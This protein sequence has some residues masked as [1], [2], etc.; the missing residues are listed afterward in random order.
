MLRSPQ[1]AGDDLSTPASRPRSHRPLGLAATV[2]AASLAANL[3]SP[4][5]VSAK[6]RAAHVRVETARLRSG[7]DESKPLVG[8]LDSG[9]IARVVDRRGG[10]ARVH[11]LSGTEGW[12][13]SDLLKVSR[14]AKVAKAEAKQAAKAK[15]LA[16]AKAAKAK[17]LAALQAK[18]LA[19]AKAAKA[20]HQAALAAQA[21]RAQKLAATAAAAKAKRLAAARLA[22]AKQIA[23]ARA[24]AQ[25]V[26][27]VRAQ[28]LAVKQI[29]QA[30]AK[31]VTAMLKRAAS[32]AA[33]MLAVPQTREH[34]VAALRPRHIPAAAPILDAAGPAMPS[35]ETTVLIAATAPRPPVQ[36]T[37]AV[38]VASLDAPAPALRVVPAAPAPALP[39]APALA[40][41]VA[42]ALPV[43]PAAP[44]PTPGERMV[45]TALTYRGTR[46]RFGARGNGAFD[47]SGFTYYLWRRAGAPL[48]RTAAQ[49][50]RRGVRIAKQNMQPGD[51]V[52]FKNTYKRGVSH[53]GVYVGDG[54]FV[55]ASSGGR[56]VRVDSL[57]RAYYVRHWAGARRMASVA[58]NGK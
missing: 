45:R 2:G 24:K 51:L 23:L 31:V 38:R 58:Q 5:S 55:H 49:Q 22:Q 52:F 41:P 9:R 27:A 54:N 1:I 34:A 25:R 29:A 37:V 18:Q 21:A 12:V 43:A 15:K 13:R 19:A 33:P 14:K 32:L 39:A 6:P 30:R 57:S 56:Q 26:A 48:P 40:V 10:W 50:Y 36:K 47:C 8:L 53:V 42:R 46:Y 28:A 17:H 16:A 20:K 35:E 11:L 4:V 7:P 44:K 3:L